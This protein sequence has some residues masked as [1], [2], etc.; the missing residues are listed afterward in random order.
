LGK[1]ND[2]KVFLVEAKSHI[3]EI[4]FRGTRATSEESLDLIKRSLEEV[5]HYLGARK[6]IDW[7]KYFYQYLNRLAHLYLLHKNGLNAH[8]VLVYFLNDYDMNG[9]KTV[10]EWK[11]ALKVMKTF[12][13]LNK[14][15]L[16]KFVIECFIDV[17]DI[18]NT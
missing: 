9:P 2:G 15:K 12:L 13:G 14:H 1:S 17:Q 18:I 8:L 7:T 5:K 4:D 10:D 3:D 11:G 16:E 6:D